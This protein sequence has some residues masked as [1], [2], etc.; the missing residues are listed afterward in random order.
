M[1]LSPAEFNYIR[2]LVNNHSA[3]ALDETKEYLV[4]MRL[5]AVIRK[6]G[7]ASI[8]ELILKLQSGTDEK[9]RL[10]VGESMTTNET[11]FFRDIHPFEA[12]KSDVMPD[13]FKRRQT[14]RT[15]SIWCAA[16]SSGQEP[17][18]I[19]MI[20]RDHFPELLGWKLDFL[21]TDI[22]EQVLTQ[23]REG[24]YNQLEVNRGLSSSHLQNH[25]QA[26]G[27]QW[28]VNNQLRKMIRFESMNLNERWLPMPPLDL[29]FI[30]NVLIYFG[31]DTR[32]KILERIG[33]MMRPDGYLF[34]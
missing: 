14:E 30:R 1:S 32:K 34:V 28:V 7:I 4:E 24:R 21:A 29:V 17:Y 20:L 6:L 13:L 8:S 2:Q 25:F 5:A 23:A 11:S 27:R 19:A 22:S 33:T 16:S 9:L 10:L 26:D 15:L 3:I 31:V 12:L 18:S